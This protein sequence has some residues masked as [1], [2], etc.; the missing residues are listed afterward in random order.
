VLVMAVAVVGW[1]EGP[2]RKRVGLAIASSLLAT[3]PFLIWTGSLL[4]RGDTPGVYRLDLATA[5]QAFG[6]ARLS[7]LNA[8]WGW[9]PWL[10]AALGTAYRAKPVVTAVLVTV[11]AGLLFWLSRRRGVR[12]AREAPGALLLGVVFAA[13]SL[14]HAGVV[15]AA[16]VLVEFPRPA[17]NERVLLPSH[18]AFV[19]GL[20][21]LG[22]YLLSPLARRRP[23]SVFVLVLLVPIVVTS[24]R[25]AQHLLTALHADGRGYTGRAWD[26]LPILTTLD[27]LPQASPLISN[28]IDAVMFFA[29][30]PAFRLPDL[31]QRI[32]AADW[33]PFGETRLR[34]PE[35]AFVEQDGYL[36]LFSSALGQLGDLYGNQAEARLESLVAGLEIVYEGYDGGIY[37]R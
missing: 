11:G 2:L 8:L 23:A 21:L 24:V 35:R 30:R 4:A 22:W 9:F 5:R 37:T 12:T 7:L 36:V 32:P 1:G 18:L 28:D 3:L 19:L 13:F 14:A 15:S 10:G 27:R 6:S 25:P 16:Y 20:V 17:L 33:R 31:E 29:N 34:L 26:G